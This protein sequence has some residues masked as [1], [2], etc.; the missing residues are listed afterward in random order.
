M[1]LVKEC[2]LHLQYQQQGR[3]DLDEKAQELENEKLDLQQL[4]EEQQSLQLAACPLSTLED[5][6]LQFRHGFS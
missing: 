6:S 4:L 2:V 5:G 3:L 1:D